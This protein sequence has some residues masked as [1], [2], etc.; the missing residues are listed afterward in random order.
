MRGQ[1]RFWL[2][3][4]PQ[5]TLARLPKGANACRAS[6]E[7]AVFVARNQGRA[8]ELY[9]GAICRSSHRALRARLRPILVR[10]E[11]EDFVFNR[12]QG[13]L[14]REVSCLVHNGVASV[15]DID[16]IVLLGSC[17]AGVW[18]VIGPF[19][20]VGLKTRAASSR[21]LRKWDERM[22][23]ERGQYDPWTPDLVAEVSRQRR[24]LLELADWENRVRWRDERLL[25]F[26]SE[27]S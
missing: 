15:A 21:M 4:P 25:T 14:L 8:V 12:L 13:A 6:R 19:E 27:G 17:A 10:R 20:T 11:V 5:F 7:P 23:A 9:V 22:G 1:T 26:L 2:V 24:A 16:D 18:S 3:Q